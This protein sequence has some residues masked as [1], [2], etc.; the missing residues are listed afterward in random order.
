MQEENLKKRQKVVDNAPG[1]FYGH[2]CTTL[3]GE[4]YDLGQLKGKVVLVE[5][6][7][8]H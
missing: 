2:A 4:P 7:A 6:V 1:A 5:N 3:A 8:S